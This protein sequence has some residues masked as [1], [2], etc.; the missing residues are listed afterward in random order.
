MTHLSDLEELIIIQND[1]L[2]QDEHNNGQFSWTSNQT[3]LLL[4]LYKKY[5]KQLGTLK[6]KSL[7]TMW[8]QIAVEIST[9]LDITITAKNCENRFK[10]LDRNYKKF[11][12]NQSGTGRGRKVF[13]FANEM[14]DLYEKKKLFIQ[15]YYY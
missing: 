14:I 2:V 10:V 7:K 13:E 1:D 9:I 5:I 15:R 12:D 11:V 8:A 6:M 4:D 3:K